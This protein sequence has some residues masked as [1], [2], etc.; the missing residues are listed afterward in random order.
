VASTDGKAW[1]S[2]SKPL[3]AGRR[4]RAGTDASRHIDHAETTEKR[5]LHLEVLISNDRDDSIHHPKNK[6]PGLSERNQQS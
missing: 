6:Q 1:N 3:P 4:L 2:Q 5:I